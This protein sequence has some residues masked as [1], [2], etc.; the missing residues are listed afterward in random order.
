MLLFHSSDLAQTNFSPHN[1]G[2]AT[3]ILWDLCL[4][5]GSMWAEQGEDTEQ[6]SSPWM[7]GL[8]KRAFRS[9]SHPSLAFL[10]TDVPASSH[11]S[12]DMLFEKA[13]KEIWGLI[14]LRSSG[15]ASFLGD[16]KIDAIP[17][18]RGSHRLPSA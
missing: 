13:C 3:I 7:T 14:S 18:L 10:L 11:V 15:E 2:L 16:C 17:V 6:A 5:G 8:P 1:Y 12:L 9:W 4:A